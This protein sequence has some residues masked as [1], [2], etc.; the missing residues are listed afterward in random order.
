MDLT[1][2]YGVYERGINK[3]AILGHAGYLKPCHLSYVIEDHIQKAKFKTE[4]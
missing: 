3:E 1:L 4:S 2:Y